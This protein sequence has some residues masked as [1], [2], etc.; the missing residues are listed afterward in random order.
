MGTPRD[1]WRPLQASFPAA[2]KTRGRHLAALTS[3][4]V[5]TIHGVPILQFR[6]A[7]SVL[8]GFVWDIPPLE[9][10]HW[11]CGAPA[12]FMGAKEYTRSG[13]R[14]NW[15]SGGIYGVPIVLP[16][17]HLFGGWAAGPSASLGTL[18]VVCSV[19][20]L[21]LLHQFCKN[22]TA[23]ALPILCFPV[24]FPLERSS[25]CLRAHPSSPFRDQT[26]TPLTVHSAAWFAPVIRPP[27]WE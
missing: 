1:S 7:G 9:D 17:Y 16:G 6:H 27:L 5:T 23:E 10:V 15:F 25:L 8:I 13:V 11:V 18:G 19:F 21:C 20:N 2:P 26:A 12:T 24:Q 4:P 22:F 3:S 14:C